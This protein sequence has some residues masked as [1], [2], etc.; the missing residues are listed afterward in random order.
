M[1]TELNH[2]IEKYWAGETSRQEEGQIR[3]YLNSGPVAEEHEELKELFDFFKSERQISLTQELDMSFVT[4]PTKNRMRFLYPKLFA[5]AASFI[6]LISVSLFL[7]QDNS[8]MYK[9]KYTELEDPEEALAIIMEALGFLSNNY[10]KG[11]EPMTKYIKNLEK[12]AVFEFN[13]S[14]GSDN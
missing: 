10:E 8:S 2:L 14:Q 6:I 5:I 12:T 3:S 4:P 13:E 1:N 11:S 7:F 9:N